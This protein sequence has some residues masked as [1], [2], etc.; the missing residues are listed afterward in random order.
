M[1]VGEDTEN[2][3]VRGYK[4]S[5]ALLEWNVIL[6]KLHFKVCVFIFNPGNSLS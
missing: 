3:V 6:D 1:Q 5:K 2:S 4:S